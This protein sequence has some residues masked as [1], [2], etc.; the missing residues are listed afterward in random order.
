[1][2]RDWYAGIEKPN[3][4]PL[5][6]GALEL[7]PQEPLARVA[8]S[9]MAD[10]SEAIMLAYLRVGMTPN[11][12][13]SGLTS[14]YL[15]STFFDE[16][17]AAPELLRQTDAGLADYAN[18]MFYPDGPMLERSPNYNES[19]ADKIRILL[20]LAGTN[21][22]PGLVTLDNKLDPY[23]GSLRSC[24]RRWAISRGSRVTAPRTRLRSGRAARRF[25]RGAPRS[26]QRS[27]L[28]QILSPLTSMQGCSIAGCRCLRALPSL[29]PTQAITS[30]VTAGA[31][32]RIF[33]TSPTRRR[34]TA[35][36]RWITMASRSAP[37]AG[38]CS[39]P[40][41]R[42]LTMSRL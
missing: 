11:Q 27:P 36:N 38:A 5:A 14:L 3:D 24:R 6:S 19:D 28:P 22:S 39:R 40:P 21:V 35:T 30:C 10:T 13:L 33:S 9:L 4:T 41:V 29:S 15:L 20:S 8:L 42:P 23:H 17:K 34:A 16:F 26:A 37:S 32:V 2:Q 31:A 12:R 18:T 7:I 1:M 25:L